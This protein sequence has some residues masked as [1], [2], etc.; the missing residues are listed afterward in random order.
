LSPG[1]DFTLFSFV[2]SAQ[3]QAVLQHN[4]CLLHTLHLQIFEKKRRNQHDNLLSSLEFSLGRAAANM[5]ISA[6]AAGAQRVRQGCARALAET[7]NGYTTSF[8]V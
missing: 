6:L 7:M 3:Q 4:D 1:G 2:S 5:K 8:E